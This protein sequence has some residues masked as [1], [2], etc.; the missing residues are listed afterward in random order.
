MTTQLTIQEAIFTLSNVNKEIERLNRRL[1]SNFTGPIRVD[2]VKI[3]QGHKAEE[4]EADL[5]LQQELIQDASHLR[6]AINQANQDNQVEG[7][8]ISYQLEWLRHTRNL[9]EHLQQLL[10][11]QSTRVENGVGVVEYGVYNEALV[12]ETI[13]TLTQKA[14][15][16]SAKIDLFNAQTTLS[17]ELIH[18]N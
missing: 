18:D 15:A 7:Q 3:T 9:L 10:E 16:L 12:N 14:N 11:S 5:Q 4:N 6:Q 1:F 2:G 13:K 8:T 17:V